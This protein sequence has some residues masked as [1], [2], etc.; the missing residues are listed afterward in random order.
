LD[1]VT[2]PDL[3][4]NWRWMFTDPRRNLVPNPQFEVNAAAWSTSNTS[5][6]R[7]IVD[8]IR[9]AGLVTATAT[10]GAGSRYIYSDLFP[11]TAG[12]TYVARAR[13]RMSTATSRQLLVNLW[14]YD[15]GGSVIGYATTASQ[16]VTAA[17]WTQL[18]GNGI[19]PT[20]AVNVRA[21]VAD[22][23]DDI[24]VS[25]AWHV[26]YV[27][28]ENT[29]DVYVFERNPR[30]MSSPYG[31]RGTTVMATP[32]DGR[33][34]AAR[35]RTPPAE[36]SFVGDIRTKSHYDALL[37]WA[38][39]GNRIHLRDHLSRT[40]EIAVT[41]F[42]PTEQRPTRKTSWRATYTMRALVFR[43]VS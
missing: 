35:G 11:V 30:E 31:D 21:I 36:W 1:R 12:Q 5:L 8:E 16:L 9:T 2:T 26:A 10:G 15:A 32:V 28:V 3:A 39:K 6:A 20:G 4:P 13:V 24:A 41:A 33:A 37:A 17:G 29:A 14:F 23:D 38:G 22:Y 18:A 19:A 42:E 34:R 27:A 25:D 40:W 7:V 43:R